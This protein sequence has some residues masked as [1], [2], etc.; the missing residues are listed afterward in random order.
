MPSP[1]YIA[2][3]PSVLLA[4]LG[5]CALILAFALAAYAVQAQGQDVTA[6][7]AATG[8]EPPVHP[9]RPTADVTHDSVTLTWAESPTESVTHYAILRRDRTITDEAGVFQVIENNAGPGLSYTDSTVA[10]ES[11][12]VYRVKAVSPTG[13]SQWSGYVNADTPAA[14]EPTATPEP[15]AE[16]TATPE[17]ADVT[18]ESAATGDDPPDPPG[19]P[20]ADIR[21]DSVT[22]TWVRSS[23]DSVT[24]YAILRRDRTTTDEAGVFQV[25]EANAGPETSYTDSTVAPESRYVYRVKAVSPTGVSQWSGYVNADT[26]AKPDPASLAPSGLS[27]APAD[28]GGVV[29][30]WDAPEEDAG[31]V[32]GYEVLRAQGEAELS[33]LAED[34]GSADTSYT[35]A[36]ATEQGETYAYRVRAL[37]GGEK[38]QASNRTAAFIPKI[39]REGGEPPVSQ[40]ATAIP[41][42]LG[43]LAANDPPW[44]IWSDGTTMWVADSGDDKL[45]AYVLTP[46]STYGNRDTSKEFNLADNTNTALDNGDPRGIWSD[47]TTMWVADSGDDKLYAYVLTPGSTYGN[48]DTSKEFNLADNTNTALDNGDPR[49]I[50]SDGTTMWVADSGDDKLYAYVLTPGSTYG[51]RDTSKEFNLADN[52]NTALDNGDPRGI[53]SDGTTMW[54]ADSGDDKLYA[55]VLT[56]GSTYGNRDTSKEFNLAD[57]TNTALD[58]GDPRGIW[59][60]GTTMWVA[61]IDDG[62]LYTYALPGA[63]ANNPATPDWSATMTVGKSAIYYGYEE[64]PDG[65][66]GVLDPATFNVGGDQYTATS[67]IQ[68]DDDPAIPSANGQLEFRLSKDLPTDFV[69]YL[70]TS[71]FQSSDATKMV[72]SNGRARYTWDNSGLSLAQDDMVAVSLKVTNTVA[73]GQPTIT[74]TA[75][76]GQTLT[77]DTSDISDDEGISDGAYAYQWTSSDDD[78]TYTDIEGATGYTYQPALADLGKTI[79]VQVSFTDNA[80]FRETVA[81]DATGAVAASLYGNVIWSATLTVGEFSHPTGRIDLGQSI[82]PFVIG[83]LDPVLFSFRGSDLEVTQFA[84]AVEADGSVK[85]LRLSLNHSLPSGDYILFLDGEPLSFE[86][87]AGGITVYNLPDHGLNW[88]EGDKVEVRLSRNLPGIPNLTA[89]AALLPEDGETGAG[90]ITLDWDP[91]PQEQGI[92]GYRIK[93][94]DNIPRTGGYPRTVTYR[95]GADPSVFVYGRSALYRFYG[96]TDGLPRD[97]GAGVSNS[98]WVDATS[99]TLP[100]GSWRCPADDTPWT[101]FHPVSVGLDPFGHQHTYD[102]QVWAISAN[103]ESEPATVRVAGPTAPPTASARPDAPVNVQVHTYYDL[104]LQQCLGHGMDGRRLRGDSTVIEALPICYED[105]EV[106]EVTYNVRRIALHWDQPDDA[107]ILRY[108]VQWKIGTAGWEDAPTHPGAVPMFGWHSYKYINNMLINEFS[109]FLPTVAGI[110]TIRDTAPQPYFDGIRSIPNTGPLAYRVRA[111]NSAGKSDWS[112]VVR[113]EGQTS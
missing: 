68:Y 105:P 42:D 110:R 55:Y 63:V 49:G 22:L 29:L 79:K 27:A 14:P 89:T 52:T 21:H 54:V 70:G 51:N 19:R 5:A 87:T 10:A 66:T 108:E 112:D 53:W 81:S 13:V 80:G 95:V 47:G 26:P 94:T 43:L 71:P 16:P 36:T 41:A 23:N 39:T 35:D 59:S 76:V 31:A 113:Y 61:D 17:P 85:Q 30:T 60:D 34:T 74:G 103:D 86:S 44:G 88:E 73:T 18:A 56:P 1:R 96:D 15:T 25:I 111:V 48:R 82:A 99:S 46:G 84:Y 102:F 6:E 106:R 72:F 107:S 58:N 9:G 8:D 62:K 100:G 38:S 12:Y 98:D 2:A 37:R 104:Q 75:Q 11:S 3:R 45:Y 57:N 32:T 24:H 101:A 33:T 50:W 109:A 65:D 83:A 7:P 67:L 77:A 93:V 69:L 91:A 4:A 20:T 92:D 78:T 40:P 28:G 64:D 90:F 97:C